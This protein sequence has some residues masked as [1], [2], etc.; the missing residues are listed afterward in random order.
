MY[1]LNQLAAGN[2]PPG[3]R[4]LVKS[5]SL[6]RV[7]FRVLNRGLRLNLLSQLCLRLSW[8]CFGGVLDRLG[9]ALGMS[10][11]CHELSWAYLAPS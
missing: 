4:Y 11:A 6:F 10:W 8:T 1:I 9:L 7:V 5:S 2:P 3:L